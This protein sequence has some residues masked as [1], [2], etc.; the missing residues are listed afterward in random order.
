MDTLSIPAPPHEDTRARVLQAALELFAERG[1][2]ATSTRELSERLGF[3][4]AALYYYFRTKDDLLAALIQ[5]VLDQL[6]ALI[7]QTPIRAS[8]A[9]RR[10]VLAAYIDLN[11]SHV[12]LLRVLTQDPSVARRP[13]SATHAALE[14]RMLQLLAGHE[15]PDLIEQ[16]R[17]R[18][19]LAA[20]RC[21]LVHA[22]PDGDPVIVRA[23]IL[24]AAC[25]ALGIPAPAPRV[26]QAQTGHAS[27]VSAVTPQHGRH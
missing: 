21:A 14:E 26:I 11:T 10:E 4:K 16:I 6:T 22:V 3:T 1:F 18:A 23:A 9:A 17:A 2:A 15:A 24:A 8:A 20:I 25:G 12:D 27:R 19:A 13:A 7:S 5:P